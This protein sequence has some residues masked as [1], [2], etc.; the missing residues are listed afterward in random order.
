MQEVFESFPRFIT[1][2]GASFTSGAGD[3]PIGREARLQRTIQELARGGEDD[4]RPRLRPAEDGG[5]V[6]QRIS[7]H[8]GEDQ[9]G[10]QCLWELSQSSIK[11]GSGER[12][13]QHPLIGRDMLHGGV[14]ESIATQ[15]VILTIESPH[16][17]YQPNPQRCVLRVPGESH[18]GPVGRSLAPAQRRPQSRVPA[19]PPGY[20]AHRGGPQ[21]QQR[22][23]S[24]SSPDS[25]VPV[26]PGAM[27]AICRESQED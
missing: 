24:G 11:V 6:L 27:S 14:A 5:Q 7:L 10:S 21:W 19:T 15:P 20:G 17:R 13:V 2:H 16:D 12:M 9:R 23:P 1:R 18:A 4:L 26:P 3:T 25:T 22:A 8:R